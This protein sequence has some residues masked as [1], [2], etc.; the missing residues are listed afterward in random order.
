MSS[1]G[2]QYLDYMDGEAPTESAPVSVLVADG[3]PAGRSSLAARLGAAGWRVVG[4]APDVR[5]ALRLS[6]ARRPALVV[7][8]IDLPGGGAILA[9][10]RIRELAQGIE[11]IVLSAQDDPQVVL[12]ALAAG[13]AGFLEKGLEPAALM[14]A[15]RGTLAGEA[16][17]DRKATRRLISE[18]R[19]LRGR[20]VGAPVTGTVARGRRLSPREREVLLLMAAEVPNRA[21]SERLGIRPETVK[22]HVRSVVRKLQAANRREAIETA[23]RIGLIDAAAAFRGPDAAA[24]HPLE[25]ES[26]PQA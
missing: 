1:R 18:Y 16:A 3:D 12:A 17:L 24:E 23:Q 2:T 25:P 22:T 13:A 19:R 15:L 26:G 6:L 5:T 21:I 4:L 10:R 11:V 9:A 20:P 8:D 14:R 7:M